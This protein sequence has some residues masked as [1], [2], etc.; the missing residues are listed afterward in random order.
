[1][2]IR[3]SNIGLKKGLKSKPIS[4]STRSSH[5]L[6]ASKKTLKFSKVVTKITSEGQVE[7]PYKIPIKTLTIGGCPFLKSVQGGD[8]GP[9]DGL[10]T[11]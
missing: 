11:A 8:I 6:N 10:Q 7:G 5:Q 2:V 3:F 1:M 4:N 9:T